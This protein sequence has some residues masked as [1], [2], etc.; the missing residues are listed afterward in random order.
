MYKDED[1]KKAY[2]KERY[3]N[4]KDMYKQ[5]RT[6]YWKKYAMKQLQ[7]EEVTEEEIRQCKNNYYRKY[8]KDNPEIIRRTLHNF[9]ERK[10]AE[11][12]GQKNES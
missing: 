8:R 2:F 7:K 12:R 6:D 9:W 10:K 3:N 4:N 5:S 1:V 11:K